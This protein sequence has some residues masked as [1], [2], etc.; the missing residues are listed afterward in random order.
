MG[1]F[2]GLFGGLGTN[3]FFDDIVGLIIVLIVIEFLCC[4][5]FNG[6]GLFGGY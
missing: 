6:N 3:N 5:I 4:C 1:I 2:N